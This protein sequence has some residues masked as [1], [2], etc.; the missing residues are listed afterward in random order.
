MPEEVHT[1]YES[2][3]V[4]SKPEPVERPLAWQKPV[5]GFMPSE[6]ILSEIRKERVRMVKRFALSLMI[7]LIAAVTGFFWKGA[8]TGN[9]TSWISFAGFLL[10]IGFFPLFALSVHWATLLVVIPLVVLAL[11]APFIKLLNVTTAIITM[12]VSAA[13]F[14]W[15]GFVMRMRSQILIKF[16]LGDIMRAGIRT[17]MLGL[18]TL[19][20][21]AYYFVV[22]PERMETQKFLIS[23]KTFSEF[24]TVAAS[25]MRGIL[26]QFSPEMSI[27]DAATAIVEFRRYALL[28]ELNKQPGFA[29]LTPDQKR[30]A[31][32]RLI[33][34]SKRNII[35]SL[36]GPMGKPLRG[37]ENLVSV[38]WSFVTRGFGNLTP[39]TQNVIKIVWGAGLG[40]AIVIAGTT[41]SSLFVFVSWILLELFLAFR[42]FEI[43]RESAER[44]ILTL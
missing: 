30:A 3:P 23:E 21:S 10:L 9:T 20:A 22:I 18:A 8:W 27:G 33:E 29:N 42:F 25:S 44:K 4:S 16:R 17:L 36:S 12:L 28:N 43:S 37:N 41:L 38:L 19:Y 32:A 13:L 31:E 39:E 7:I 6:K 2:A 35:N 24:I 26:P 14:V 5:A 34:E 11:F 40:F 1:P 15:A